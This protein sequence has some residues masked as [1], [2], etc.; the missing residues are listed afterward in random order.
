[1]IK[2]IFFAALRDKLDCDGLTIETTSEITC[3]A[4]IKQYLCQKHPHWQPFFTEQSIL[5]AVNHTM[6]DESFAV[7]SG[8]EVAFF[9][10]V[11]G[12]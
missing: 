1:M 10:P 3:V 12:G 8:D 6:A 5:S 9:P 7:T 4:D 11:T 2:V